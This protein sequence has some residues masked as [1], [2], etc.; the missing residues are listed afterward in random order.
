M[1]SLAR[2]SPNHPRQG[3]R[4]AATRHD[5][6]RHLGQR[7]A[8]AAH[9]IGEVAD[10]HCLQPAG[11][12][13]T[14]DHG[15]DRHRQLQQRIAAAFED[16]VLVLPCRL[17]HAAALLQIAAGTKDTVA[18]AGQ[19]DTA[20]VSRIVDQPC[21]QVEQVEPHLRVLGVA[22]L[23]AVQRHPQQVVTDRF[24]QD[25]FVGWHLSAARAGA[26]SRSH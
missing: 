18:G 15:D 14:I 13:V 16:L 20:R 6:D 8:R 24:G 12:G 19:H 4:A 10:Q 11:I 7:E 5:A 21:P 26:A 9:G 3:L 2:R 1:I 17:R 22:H 23:G 25:G